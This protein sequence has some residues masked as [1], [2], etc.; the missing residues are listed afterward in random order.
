MPLMI[1]ATDIDTALSQGGIYIMKVGFMIGAI[2][3]MV[4]GYSMHSGNDTGAMMS[5]VGGLIMACAVP[6]MKS[7]FT[8]AGM[9]DGAVNIGGW[10]PLFLISKPWRQFV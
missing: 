10:L 2:L 4:G 7:F 5:I 9:P 1:G 8:V 6:F 3:I